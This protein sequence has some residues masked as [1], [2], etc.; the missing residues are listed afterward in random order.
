MTLAD[1]I[2]TVGVH[3][4]IMP[5]YR[6]RPVCFCT[7]DSSQVMSAFV[8]LNEISVKTQDRHWTPAAANTPR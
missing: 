8:A 6:N 2:A 7:S 3:G 1:Q 4:Q 5:I